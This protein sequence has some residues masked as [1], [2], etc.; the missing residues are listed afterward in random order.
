MRASLRAGV[1]QLGMLILIA[2]AALAADAPVVAAPSDA[3][4][5]LGQVRAE[6]ERARLAAGGG[7]RE[8]GEARAEM[9]TLEKLARILAEQRVAEQRAQALAEEADALTEHL[10]AP[11]SANVA[12]APPYSLRFFDEAAGAAEALRHAVALAETAAGDALAL[13]ETARAES[14]EEA[15]VLRL[16]REQ[17][18][19]QPS[20]QVAGEERRR[21]LAGR[22][23]EARV[24]LRELDHRNALAALE[25]ERKRLQRSDAE[26]A[27]I[28]EHVDARERDLDEVRTE[29]AQEEFDA[30]RRLELSRLELASAE[31]RLAAAQRRIGAARDPQPAAEEEAAARRLEVARYQRSVAFLGER[32]ERV[33][34][35][36]Q[37]WERRYQL[38]SDRASRVEVAAWFEETARQLEETTRQIRIRATRVEE[39]R[40][41][42]EEIRAKI[43]RASDPRVGHWLGAQSETLGQLIQIYTEDLAGLASHR[44]LEQRLHAEL[45]ARRT[46]VDLSD[47]IRALFDVARSAWHYEITSSENRAITVGKAVSAVVVFLIGY[48]FASAVTRIGGRRVFSRVGMDEGAAHAFESLAFYA[49]MVAAFLFALRIVNIPLTAFAVVGG[50]LAIGVGFGSQNVVNNFI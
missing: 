2:P 36:R 5:Q 37:L 10:A 42:S 24:R 32:L 9:E 44:A 14:K 46:E 12:A 21:E 18:S 40:R 31:E 3:E 47:R 29:L 26:L 50:A 4:R 34:A 23:A 49:L 41:Q 11:P 28:R 1:L 43:E 25:L 16:A 20:A 15:R 39:L 7:G 27:W 13:L 48:L 22:L 35:D 30:A 6:I 38:V 17:R 45:E 33:A 8:A 19:P